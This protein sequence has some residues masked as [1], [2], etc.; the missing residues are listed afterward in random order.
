MDQGDRRVPLEMWANPVRDEAGNVESAVVAFQ[1]ISRRKQAE[2]EL[3]EY[4]K[5]LESLV[6]KRTAELNAS[7][8]ELRLRLEWMS[9]IVL[10][11]EA[12][13][14]SSD[15]SQIYEKIIE[16]I[17]RLLAIQDTFIA[18]LDESRDHLK[19]LA[20]SCQ[21]ENHP[22]L[23]GSFTTIPANILDHPIQEPGQARLYSQGTSSTR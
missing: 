22:E 13:A 10:V 4:R 12:M 11:T 23:V 14:R 18:E 2:A 20:H 3:G 7:N 21:R 19:I 5:Q 9:A 16:I 6:E 8:K 17:N 1:D 15:F